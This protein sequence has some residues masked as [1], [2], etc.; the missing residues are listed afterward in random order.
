MSFYTVPRTPPHL[1][2]C[3]MEVFGTA[4]APELPT[5]LSVLSF[6]WQMQTLEEKGHSSPPVKT[7]SCFHEKSFFKKD[8]QLRT[9]VSIVR[10]ITES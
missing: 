7:D 8:Q 3:F 10:I 6:C 1:P 4:P 2:E 5:A 9:E